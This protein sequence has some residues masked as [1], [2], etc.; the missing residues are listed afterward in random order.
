VLEPAA[1]ALATRRVAANVVLRGGADLGA[2]LASFVL[3]IVPARKLGATHFGIFTYAL[4]LVALVSAFVDSGQ[5]MVLTREVA[6]NER[7][8][9]DYFA[10]TLAIQVAVGIPGMLLALALGLANG[11][12]QTVQVVALLGAAVIV[13]ALAGTCSAVFAAFDRFSLVPFAVV[14]PRLFVA[15]AGIGAVYSGASVRDVALIYL[16]GSLLGLVLA[17]T[18]MVRRVIRPRLAITPRLWARLLRAAAPVLLV[19]AFATVLLRVDTAM[20]GLFKPAHAVGEYGAAYRFFDAVVFI[21]WSAGAALLPTF[22]RGAGRDLRGIFFRSSAA[23]LVLG[24]VPAVVTA[25]FAKPLVGGVYGSG[26]SGSITATRLLA[27]ALALYPL[28]QVAGVLLLAR[29]RQRAVSIVV[30][31]VAAENIALNL[32]LI[33]TWS[34][35]GA[36]LGTSLSQLLLTVPLLVYA[37][38]EVA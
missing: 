38:R 21:S 36:A 33:P 18:L 16:A 27:P 31:L 17:A 2:K 11:G 19:G 32:F 1:P 30:G 8:L 15:L 23:A 14:P 22:S 4:S 3:L 26:Y 10:N 24:I 7:V 37:S 28:G 6:R 29:H 34:L 5:R 12:S 20:L 25:A 35:D 9:D 13:D